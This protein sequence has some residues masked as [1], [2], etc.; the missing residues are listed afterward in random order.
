M[1]IEVSKEI[2]DIFADD[3]TRHQD[4]E[5][6]GV[7]DDEAGSHEGLDGAQVVQPLV[8]QGY[9]LAVFLVIGRKEGLSQHP[10]NE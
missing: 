6:W 3:L 7:W 8:P 4:G 2:D 5:A 9:I 1:D 10:L